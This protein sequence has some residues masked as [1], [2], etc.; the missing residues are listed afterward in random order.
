MYVKAENQYAQF[1][2]LNFYYIFVTSIHAFCV[3]NPTI[4]CTSFTLPIAIGSI[5]KNVTRDDKESEN[6]YSN[7]VF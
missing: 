4:F 6:T 1:L 7:I 3:Q 2:P 5:H